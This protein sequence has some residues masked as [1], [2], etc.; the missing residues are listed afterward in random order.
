MFP[1][2]DGEGNE[3]QEQNDMIS[4]NNFC[5]LISSKRNSA[6]MEEMKEQTQPMTNPL[7][8]YFV[9]CDFTDYSLSKNTAKSKANKINVYE[10][11]LKRGCRGLRI[12]IEAGPNS[13]PV[14]KLDT[15]NSA[16]L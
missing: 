6:F 12:I 7:S 15:E 8:D 11:A 9:Y 5:S 14:V 2:Y 13:K 10:M 4:F 1:V 3:K 16:D